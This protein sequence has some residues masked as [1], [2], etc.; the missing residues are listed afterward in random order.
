MSTEREVIFRKDCP[1]GTVIEVFRGP[2]DY[3]AVR[4]V[5]GDAFKCESVELTAEEAWKLRH[6]LHRV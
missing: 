5:I 3:G 4:I 6:A 2:Y 1:D